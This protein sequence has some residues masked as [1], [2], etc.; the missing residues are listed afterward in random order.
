M[1]LNLFHKIAFSYNMRTSGV[2]SLLPAA[3]NQSEFP[4]T[5]FAPL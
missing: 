3:S 4:P 1:K 2:R 5:A